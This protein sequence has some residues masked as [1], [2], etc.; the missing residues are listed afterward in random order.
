[1][2]RRMRLPIALAGSPQYSLAR[3][4]LTIATFW[5]LWLSFHVM[6]RPATIGLPI[7]VK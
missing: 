5:K 3:F 1:M 6:P 4:S 2:V 7:V